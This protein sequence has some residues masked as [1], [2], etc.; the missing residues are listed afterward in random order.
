MMLLLIYI[1]IIIIIRTP[2][3]LRLQFQLLNRREAG[4]RLQ[5][6]LL[7]R[8][9]AGLRLQFRFTGYRARQSCWLPMLQ[10]LL[11]GARI[12]TRASKFLVY[13]S[14]SSACRH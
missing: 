10:A 9:E 8:R 12:T 1:I 14:N 5:F 3:V 2:T 13:N 4:L 7:N 6:Q 11:Y